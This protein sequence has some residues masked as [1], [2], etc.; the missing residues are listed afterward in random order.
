MHQ[1]VGIRCNKIGEPEKNMRDY[2]VNFY[3]DANVYFLVDVRNCDAYFDESIVQLDDDFLI[4]HSL[5]NVRDWGWRC[6]DYFYYAFRKSVK[7]DAYWLV[8]P[9]VGFFL[10]DP[11]VFFAKC[12]SLSQDFLAVFYGSRDSSWAWH[13]TVKDI[14]SNVYGC[15]FSFSRLSAKAIDILFELRSSLSRRYLDDSSTDVWANDEAFVATVVS[16]TSD[17][18]ALNL[19]D[20]FNGYFSKFGTKDQYLINTLPVGVGVVHPVLHWQDFLNKFKRRYEIAS[21]GNRLDAF[22]QNSL[23]GLS[24]NQINQLISCN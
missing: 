22:L 15:T 12:K 17:L 20:N 19:V 4:R 2:L 3:G 11:V 10:A 14:S 5:L 16:I 7:A 24:S 6:G 23:V 21:E 8:E 18:T 1:V 13:P 9:D